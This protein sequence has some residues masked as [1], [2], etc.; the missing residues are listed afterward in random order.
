MKNLLWLALLLITQTIALANENAG[1]D[2]LRLVLERMPDQ[3]RLVKLNEL[4]TKGVSTLSKSMVELLLQEAERQHNDTY[5]GNAYFLLIRYYYN[6]SSD[7]M[8]YFIKQA[9]PIYLSENRLEELFRAKAW[10]IY[11]LVSEGMEPM[12]VP[13]VDALRKLSR[14]LNYPEGE[15]MAGQALADY[16]FNRGLDAEGFKQYQDVLTLME[17]RNAPP[18]KRFNVIRHLVN[19]GTNDSLHTHYIQVL[20]DFIKTCEQEGIDK[21][22]QDTSLDY[23]RYVYHRTLTLDACKK[24]DAAVARKHLEEAERIVKQHNLVVE[25][26]VMRNL[27]YLYYKV[28]G[29]YDQALQAADDLLVDLY[30]RKRIVAYL[31]ILQD[32]GNL[33]YELE[34]K[35]QAADV[36]RKY[37]AMKDSV[38]SAEFYNDLAKY[39]AQHDMDKLEIHAK[40]LALDAAETHSYLLQMGGG[41][42]LLALICCTLGFFAYS[43]HKY[44]KRLKAAKEKAEEADRM[45]SAFLANM[46]HEIRTPLNA[47][48]GF[49]QVLV[50]E[51][52]AGARREYLKIIQNNN[53]LLQ[54][55]ICDVLDLSKIESNSMAFSYFSIYLPELMDEIY[56]ATALRMP[57]GV[58]LILAECPNINFYTDRNRLTQII[59]NLLNNSIKHT[60]S[61]HIRF[62][63]EKR[64][65]ELFFFVEDTG[66]GIPEDKLD[67]IFSRFVQLNDWNK[68]VGLGLAI[69]KGLVSN[70]GGAIGVISE[71]GK[72]SVF[73]VNLP[74]KDV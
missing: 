62:G 66:E 37:I 46:N 34:Q 69:C 52:D 4:A 65:A 50:D 47:I 53:E 68:G 43:R 17:K 9:E 20:S 15:E 70:M 13:E 72:G 71:F 60:Q 29:M 39:R 40:Q 61:G 16:Y 8:R 42:I 38:S 48:V 28:A 45:K 21:L 56:K 27:R 22:D 23:A 44:G 19:N 36:Y 7:S 54:R 59:T 18:G 51:D 73:T 2:S 24:K 6:T 30:Q 3:E 12:I 63:Y 41:V 55:L 67:S 14:K 58:K 74:Y 49:S 57:E 25:M 1:G 33:Y 11:R 32:K 64:E 10:L 35:D 26:Q 5:K 31:Q